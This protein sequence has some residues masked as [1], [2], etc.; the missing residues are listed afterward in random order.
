MSVMIDGEKVR[1]VAQ[2]IADDILNETDN[3]LELELAVAVFTRIMNKSISAY[4]DI[5][6]LEALK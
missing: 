2:K 1:K 6:S 5:K 4:L 3:L